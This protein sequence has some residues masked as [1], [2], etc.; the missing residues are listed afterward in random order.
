M[1]KRQS[2]EGLIIDDEAALAKLVTNICYGNP[3][4]RFIARPS[5]RLQGP[6]QADWIFL[7][8]AHS[9][10]ICDRRGVPK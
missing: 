9:L 8:A 7:Q 2:C 3:A 5:V 4:R 6:E 10:E 1:L